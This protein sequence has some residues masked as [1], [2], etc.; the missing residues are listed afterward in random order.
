MCFYLYSYCKIGKYP[1][2]HESK[3]I[4]TVWFCSSLVLMRI[5]FFLIAKELIWSVIK[6]VIWDSGPHIPALN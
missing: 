2:E 6:E 5:I 1:M 3:G 4:R